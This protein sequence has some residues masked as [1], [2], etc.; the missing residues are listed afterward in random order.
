MT[1]R[2]AA[3]APAFSDQPRDATTREH[4]QRAAKQAAVPRPRAS[5]P[6]V[7]VVSE[8]SFGN[9]VV[10]GVGLSLGMFLFGLVVWIALIVLGAFVGTALLPS[11]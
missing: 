6:Q 7:V 11:F 4:R 8:R 2:R 9:W 10:A 3:S 1:D 5:A